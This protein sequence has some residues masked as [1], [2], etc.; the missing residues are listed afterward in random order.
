MGE[1]GDADE[2][3]GELAGA[4]MVTSIVV[5]AA[6]CTPGTPRWASTRM[7][8]RLPPSWAVES[9]EFTASRMMQMPR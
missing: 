9:R 3:E 8:T 2:G 1:D 7:P 6:A 5:P 4:S